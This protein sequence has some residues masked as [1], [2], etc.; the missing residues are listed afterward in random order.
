[1][2]RSLELSLRAAKVDPHCLAPR[3]AWLV[4]AYSEVGV[5]TV[6]FLLR[7]EFCGGHTAWNEGCIDQRERRGASHGVGERKQ[8]T[9]H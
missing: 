1:M 5:K 8:D 7:A 4:S 2:T 6:V 3:F 9:R